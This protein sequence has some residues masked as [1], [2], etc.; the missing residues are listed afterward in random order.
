MDLATNLEFHYGILMWFLA[1]DPWAKPTTRFVVP[2]LTL[3]GE[4]AQEAHG[5]DLEH[6]F[7]QIARRAASAAA[8]EAL[9]ATR[10]VIDRKETLLE[11]P[12]RRL[13]D[14]PHF[15]SAWLSQ[16]RRNYVVRDGRV[17]WQQNP[18]DVL[19]ETYRL[20]DM[21]TKHA[22]PAHRIWDHDRALLD[23]AIAFYS[24]L[25]T[26]VPTRMPWPDLD[27]TLKEGV[28][29]FGFDDAAWARV[30]AAHAGHQLGLEILALLPLIADKVGFEDLRLADD[31]TIVIPDRLLDT[32][33]QDA[34]RK[35]LVPPPA[36]K[37]D[38]IVSAMGGTFY[39]QEAPHLPPFL[40]KGAHF[41]KG[42]ALYII[43][44]MKMFNKVLATFAGTVTE[45]LVETGVVVRKGQPLFK[46]R[47]DEVV[48]EEDPAER[49]RRVRAKTESY[50]A[51]L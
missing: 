21:D 33:H 5:I 29:A 26:R 43:E 18:V 9:E 42:D 41:E 8:P 36:T 2:Y 34:M 38:E 30:R 4:L 49:E 28:P 1:R 24:K 13:F 27:A 7:Q 31:L 48:V 6:A 17:E 39:T 50:L 40:T 47:P 12:I 11:R 10:Q 23:R 22:A 16:H 45:V 19:A 3:V 37:A 15:L 14:E 51:R 32:K 35:V 20:V 46:I 25:A 44:V